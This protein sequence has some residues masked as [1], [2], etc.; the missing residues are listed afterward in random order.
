MNKS[1]LILVCLFLFGAKI[2]KATLSGRGRPRSPVPGMEGPLPQHEDF[3]EGLPLV[4]AIRSRRGEQ[5]IIGRHR[6]TGAIPRPFARGQEGMAL[7]LGGGVR[8][9]RGGL[10][11]EEVV[12]W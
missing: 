10:E 4:K 12:V 5:L 1:L 3:P 7:G 11:A 9:L 8:F 2:L 6:R